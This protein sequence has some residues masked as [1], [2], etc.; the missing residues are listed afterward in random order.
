LLRIRSFEVR[1]T[2]EGEMVIKNLDQMGYRFQKGETPYHTY[3]LDLGKN[4]NEIRGNF[5][6]RWR[7]K[8]NRAERQDLEV[9]SGTDGRMIQSFKVLYKD[10]LT[11]K[12]FREYVANIDAYSNEQRTLP[13]N[14]KMR[15]F[16]C[17]FREETVAGAVISLIGD[18]AMCLLAATSTNC[19][20]LKLNAAYLIQWRVIEWLK[21]RKIQYYDLRGGIDDGMTGVKFFKSGLSGEEIY[22]LGSFDR[23]ERKISLI[24]VRGGEFIQKLVEK[25]KKISRSALFPESDHEGKMDSKNS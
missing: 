1:G 14:L 10:L 20:N 8:L 2:I 19:I 16:L 15:I 3:R 11:R 9:L 7:R 23:C 6:K 12:K 17:K 25:R 22:Y 18:T 13:E 24:F 4:L 21:E 5:R